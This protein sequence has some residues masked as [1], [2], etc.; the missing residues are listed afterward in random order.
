MRI[1]KSFLVIVFW[2]FCLWASLAYAQDK[3]PNPGGSLASREKSFAKM[4]KDKD[5]MI[6]SQEFKGDVATFLTI[7]CNHDQILSHD[8]YVFA[9]C[10]ID[11]KEMAFRALDQNG[12]G[13]IELKEW[14]RTDS[15]FNQ[16]DRDQNGVLTRNEINPST[17]S[18]ILREI[19]GQLL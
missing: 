4:D 6:S 14:Q 9:D 18:K 12:N 19:L 7:D 5:Q 13:V 2:L 11:K 3:K 1:L 17:K 8:E 16:L 15:E 10:K